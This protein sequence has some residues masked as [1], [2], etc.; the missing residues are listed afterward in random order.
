MRNRI[1][2]AAA[3]AMALFA[4]AAG[5]AA[6]SEVFQ[7]SVAEGELGRVRASAAALTLTDEGETFTVICEVQM[8]LSLARS[9][10]GVSGTSAGSARE[11]TVRNC[12]GGEVRLLE[13]TWS[14]AYA[15]FSGTLP[16]FSAL[17]FRVS[18][19][20]LLLRA[21]FGASQCLYGGTFEVTTVGGATVT[22]LRADES[23]TVPLVTRLGGIVC[24]ASGR[25]RGSLRLAPAVRQVGGDYVL[26]AEPDDNTVAAG[27]FIEIFLRNRSTGNLEVT[28]ASVVLSD[29]T[30]FTLDRRALALRSSRIPPGDEVAIRVTAEAGAG[31]GERTNVDI[32]YDNNKSVRARVRV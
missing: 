17:R 12:R 24:P 25:L 29:A 15:S 7:Q 8:N 16:T 18:G 30:H 14:I 13:A 10:A 11:A 9:I 23:R 28:V 21:F 4:L 27:D 20:G 26:G 5:A 2:L 32:T 31:A 22:E 6:A 3:L 19:V 1:A